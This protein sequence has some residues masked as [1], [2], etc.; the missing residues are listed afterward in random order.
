MLTRPDVARRTIRRMDIASRITPLRIVVAGGGVAAIE[1]LLALHDLGERRFRLAV[2]AP[3]DEFVLRPMTVAVP[4][5]AG[6]PIRVPID[7]I[8][9][10][11]G[12]EH[13]RAA[14]REVDPEARVVRSSDGTQLSYDVLVLAVGAVPSRA[15]ARGITFDDTDLGA[16]DGLL[17]EIEQ[18]L[19]DSVA[20][21]VPPGAT[22]TLPAYEL[23]LLTARH[24]SEAGMHAVRVHLVTPEAVPLALFGSQ[25]S[26]AVDKLLREFDVVIH[27][28]SYASVAP[29][30]RITLTP[31]AVGLEVARIVALPLVSGR[32]I[33]GIPT[34]DAGFVPVDRHARVV[35][36]DGV[37]AAGDN[38]D[39]PIKQ[40]GLA[41]QQ[42]DAAAHH[43]AA[44]A[45]ASVEA[46]P[47]RPVLRG[48]LLTGAE[49]LFLRNE[50]SGGRGEG[51]V[52]DSSLWWPPV[53]IMGRYL[54][55]WLAGE[56]GLAPKPVPQQ[57]RESGRAR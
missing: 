18:G 45:G 50:I 30:G 39:F 51:R 56:E 36:T 28:A 41:T 29:S 46:E 11:F 26:A 17:R 54:S 5:S 35:G 13:H 43:I 24:A 47:F 31:G 21:I 38:T 40:G 16:V 37:Y 33:V 23:A 55:L 34:D 19:C 4:F 12:A 27:T 53:K 2:V 49:P 9:A 52:S 8:C 6:R 57:A 15:Y 20:V 44:R 48:M 22:W 10:R 14:V 25:A 7:E 3:N 1:S 32:P 42:A